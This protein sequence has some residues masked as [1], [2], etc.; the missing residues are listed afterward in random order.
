MRKYFMVKPYD[1]QLPR[2]PMMVP[3]AACTTTPITPLQDV[4]TSTGEA[5]HYE[6]HRRHGADW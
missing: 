3:N 6:R 1:S 5:D 2:A 4:T